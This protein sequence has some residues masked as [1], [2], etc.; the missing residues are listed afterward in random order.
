M[1]LWKA[2]K[3]GKHQKRPCTFNILINAEN[4]NIQ[5]WKKNENIQF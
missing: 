2:K 1:T 3:D 4:E 5:F